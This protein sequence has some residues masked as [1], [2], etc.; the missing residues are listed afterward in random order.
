MPGDNLYDLE[1]D[2]DFLTSEAE[3]LMAAKLG[4]PVRDQTTPDAL[5]AVI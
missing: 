1:L 5:C 4:K 2:S 3:T